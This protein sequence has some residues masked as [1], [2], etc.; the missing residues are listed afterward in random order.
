[1]V[2]I[3]VMVIVVV[4]VIVVVGLSSCLVVGIRHSEPEPAEVKNLIFLRLFTAF[5]VT[6]DVYFIFHSE[7]EI[8]NY[9][10]IIH[11]F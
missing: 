8:L 2:V 3:V 6:T 1:M 9:S 11:H 10:F 5:R 4:I 7:S